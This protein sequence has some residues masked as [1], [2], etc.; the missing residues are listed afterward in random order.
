MELDPARVQA[1]RVLVSSSIAGLA[2]ERVAVTDL[3]SGR[4]HSGPLTSQPD[5]EARALAATD[6]ALA[7]RIAHE[8]HLAAKVR[9]SLGFLKGATVDVSVEFGSAETASMPVPPG[10][11]DF[12][13]DRSAG[14]DAGR[15]GGTQKPAAANA[16]AEIKPRSAIV[17]AAPPPPPSAPAPPAAALPAAV[18]LP[19]ARAATAD[20][21]ESILVSIAVPDTY[22]QAACRAAAER[23]GQPALQPVAIEAQ[24]TERIRRHVLSLLPATRDPAQRRVVITGFPVATPAT[25]RREQ[26]GRTAVGGRPSADRAAAVV[27]GG[28]NGTP[29]G[30]DDLVDVL[31]AGR[32]GDVPRQVWLAATSV[33]V[34]LLA[35]ALWWLGGRRDSPRAGRPPCAAV[36]QPRIDWSGVGEPRDVDAAHASAGSGFGRAAVLLFALCAGGVVAEAAG[37]DSNG[38]VAP[39]PESIVAEPSSAGDWPQPTA[40]RPASL[41]ASHRRS[42]VSAAAAAPNVLPAVPLSAA[43]GSPASGPQAGAGMFVGQSGQFTDWKLLAVIVAAFGVVAA[44]TAFSKRRAAILPPDVFEVLGEGSL[45]GQHAVRI[46]R[47][48]PKTLLVGVSSA[49]CQTLAELSDPQATACIAAACRGVHPPIRPAAAAR[50]RGPQVQPA[51]IARAGGEAA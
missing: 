44:V 23:A 15:A 45:G 46:V 51:A 5:P 24:E 27:A 26:S 47:F 30:V 35:G 12:E 40:L 6:P 1:I 50:P 16:P 22:F 36:Q 48:G 9:Q 31:A 33:C 19:A 38:A 18:A 49:G 3:R 28:A 2:P 43:D 7:R 13:A 11:D 37:P 4:V 21:P 10:P 42:S 8:Q 41:D 20:A 29:G 39:L 14:D 32:L 34:G 17:V 25:A